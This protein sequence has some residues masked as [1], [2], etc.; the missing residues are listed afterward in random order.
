[1]LV[2]CYY[3]LSP[4]ADFIYPLGWYMAVEENAHLTINVDLGSAVDLICR[5]CEAIQTTDY[6][7]RT[8]AP[9]MDIAV[10]MRG[11]HGLCSR[12]TS[13]VYNHLYSLGW[14]VNV[15]GMENPFMIDRTKKSVAKN[16]TTIIKKEKTNVCYQH[17]V[18]G[19]ESTKSLLERCKI[20][21]CLLYT[22]PSPRD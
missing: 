18:V 16:K 9:G 12:F 6:G 10:L 5:C 1:M 20:W 4:Y 13:Q 17:D 15:K 8:E 11:Q 2:A 22:S 19:P 3:V 7:V 14:E 21:C